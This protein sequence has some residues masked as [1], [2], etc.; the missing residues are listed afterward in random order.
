VSVADNSRTF[1]Q[2]LPQ[3][4]E[5]GFLLDNAEMIA[6]GA[7]LRQESRGSH[8]RR[9]FSE[10]DDSNWLKHTIITCEKERPKVTFEPVRV[11]MFQPERRVY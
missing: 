4:I 5:L 3:V 10:R 7:H 6:L 1:N 2:E 9:D 8:Y 11:T